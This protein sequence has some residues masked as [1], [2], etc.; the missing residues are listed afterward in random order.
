MAKSFINQYGS[1]TSKRLEKIKDNAWNYIYGGKGYNTN[2]FLTK[3]YAIYQIQFE[4][5]VELI[6]GVGYTLGDCMA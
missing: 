5:E 6:G 3:K 1:K 4:K 2:K